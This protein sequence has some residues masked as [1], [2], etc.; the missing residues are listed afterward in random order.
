[1]H[2]LRMIALPAM[3]VGLSPIA[4]DRAQAH[5][6]Y[7]TTRVLT[8]QGNACAGATRCKI[9]ADDTKRIK[10]GRAQNI[11]A[12]CP[13]DRPYFVNWDA[14]HHEHIGIRL[15]QRGFGG[16][17]VTAVNHADVP[18]RV[19]LHIGCAKDKAEVSAQLQAL[20]A[21]P[22]KAIKRAQP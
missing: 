3:L 13:A 16:V 4:I 10:A 22:T 19:T 14:T 8:Q 2:A 18:G 21:L 12:R 17:K 7:D 11:T 6:L 20:D 1:M 9:I 15:V 5:P